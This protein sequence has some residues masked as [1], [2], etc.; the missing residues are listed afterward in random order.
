VFYGTFSV[1]RRV[2]I[3]PRGNN[4]EFLSMYLDVA[5][6]SVL[7]Y[8]WTRYAQFSL[9]VVNQIHSKFTIRKGTCSFL[10]L[11][12]ANKKGDYGF[13]GLQ[14]MHFTYSHPTSANHPL[15]H[16]LGDFL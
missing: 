14:F 2:L 12:L 13:T 8:G 6:S 3:F 15:R 9:S 1:C 7:P 11:P 4:V 5:D 16:L 10:S